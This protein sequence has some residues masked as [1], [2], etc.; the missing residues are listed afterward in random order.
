MIILNPNKLEVNCTRIYTNKLYNDILSINYIT[1]LILFSQ[2]RVHKI[3]N[4]SCRLKKYI[5]SYILSY[6]YF[7]LF[8]LISWLITLVSTIFDPW[9]LYCVSNVTM[10]AEIKSEIRI[11]FIT[12]S[13]FFIPFLII[14]S[15]NV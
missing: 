12:Y 6:F 2:N 4:F 10:Y 3:F 13:P 11:I 8:C 15:W 14:A 1:T 7:R 5:N 9:N